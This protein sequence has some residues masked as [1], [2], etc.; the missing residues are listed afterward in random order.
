MIVNGPPKFRITTLQAG[1]RFA[2]PGKERW[3][4]YPQRFVSVDLRGQKLLRARTVASGKAGLSQKTLI[5][6]SLGFKHAVACFKK[7][8]LMASPISV[9]SC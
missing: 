6:T 9:W 1:K 5:A 8:F 2:S 7:Q 3:L 4:L